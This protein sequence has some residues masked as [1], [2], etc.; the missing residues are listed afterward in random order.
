MVPPSPPPHVCI[1][2][3]APT[4]PRGCKCPLVPQMSWLNPLCKMGC[5]G[6]FM[7][8]GACR[9]LITK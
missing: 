8:H 3:I 5:F 7:Q 1:L 4:P 9:G 2:K 6:G